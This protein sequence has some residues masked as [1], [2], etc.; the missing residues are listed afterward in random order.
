MDAKS[1]SSMASIRC[2]SLIQ[3]PLERIDESLDMFSYK[4]VQDIYT[5]YGCILCQI[6]PELY[7]RVE[8]RLNKGLGTDMTRT[9][10][11][12][13]YKACVPTQ[14]LLASG[15]PVTSDDASTTKTCTRVGKFK[16]LFMI[17]MSLLLLYCMMGR[18]L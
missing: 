15:L 3:V 6:R 14:G 16:V 11:N 8:T 7:H 9:K 4:D 18:G 10:R 13:P 17:R 12:N 1:A 5:Y 2:S